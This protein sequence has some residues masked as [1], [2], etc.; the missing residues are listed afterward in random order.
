MAVKT[1]L[2][3]AWNTNEVIANVFEVRAQAENVYN[4][5]QESIARIN[6]ITAGASFSDVDDEIKS[7]GRDIIQILNQAKQAF[8]G[9]AEFLAWRQPK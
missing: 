3:Q 1:K 8:D 4:V 5:L 7:E 2:D 6:E 9:H